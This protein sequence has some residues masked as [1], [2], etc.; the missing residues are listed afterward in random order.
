MEEEMTI[1]RSLNKGTAIAVPFLNI[2]MAV[3][4]LG[5][6]AFGQADPPPPK[7]NKAE[8]K[9]ED[10]QKAF[11]TQCGIDFDAAKLH[12]FINSSKG[13]KEYQDLNALP[14]MSSGVDSEFIVRSDS[15]GKHYVR[16]FIPGEDFDRYQDDCFGEAGKLQRFRYEM[17][18]A[19]GWGYEES[20]TFAPSGKMVDKSSRF[21]DTRNEKTIQPPGRAKDVP[22][23]LKPEV[24]TEFLGMPFIPFLNE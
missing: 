6:L 19:W 18:T 3:L 23:A 21:F 15:A 8:Q 17:R 2:C 9:T 5:A 11:A 12:I 1:V 20:R 24:H 22:E 16:T 13:W 4:F 7:E 14:E 10:P